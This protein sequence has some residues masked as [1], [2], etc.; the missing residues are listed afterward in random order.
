MTDRATDKKSQLY[1]KKPCSTP[2]HVY[3][4]KIVDYIMPYPKIC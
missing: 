1:L 3:D 4:P 2:E